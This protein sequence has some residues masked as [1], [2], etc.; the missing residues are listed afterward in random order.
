LILRLI[1][2]VLPIVK[3]LAIAVEEDAV[4]FILPG[5]ESFHRRD[6]IVRRP[7]GILGIL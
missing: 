2:D 1:E 3:N 7:I 4:D 6:P 5:I